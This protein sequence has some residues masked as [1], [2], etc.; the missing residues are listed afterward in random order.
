MKKLLTLAMVA[1]MLTACGSKGLKVE[2]PKTMNAEYGE[3]LNK[4]KLFDAKK[5][6]KNVE[7]KK[8]DGFDKAKLGEQKVKVT[9][10]DG[11]EEVVKEIKINVKDTKAP[12]FKK[13]LKEIRIEKNAENVNIKDYFNVEDKSETEINIDL[14]KINFSK[15]GKYEIE[16]SAKDKHGNKSEVKKCVVIVVDREEAVK[17]G[18]TATKDGHIPMSKETKKKGVKIKKAEDKIEQPVKEESK[19]EESKKETEN[20]HVAKPS[21]DSKPSNDS[22]PQ[23]DSR[24]TNKP[25]H[26]GNESKPSHHEHHWVAQYKTVHHE[27][28]GHYEKIKIQDAWEEAEQKEV[29]VCNQC[30]TIITVENHISHYKNNPNCGGYHGELR[31][32]G[33][34]IHHEA[35]YENEYVIDQK[36]Y[37]EKILTGYKCSCGA[38][39]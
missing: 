19:Q 4:D 27:E 12:V 29:N 25:S 1:A 36:A 21:T 8:V 38:T 22:K 35:V 13:F 32:T 31:P 39:K 14:S 28:K 15:A 16:V 30:G 17:N 9:F 7:V 33:N 20:K 6:D 34:V 11:K 26:G 37:D 5:S 3:E 2:A 24:P 10:S 18:L 23:E